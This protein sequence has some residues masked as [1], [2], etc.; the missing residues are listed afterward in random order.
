MHRSGLRVGEVLIGLF[1]V[2]VVWI[3][4]YS[5]RRP[6]MMRAQCQ[7]NL[8]QVSL[9]ILQY[10]RDWSQTLPPVAMS[11]A[12]ATA[13]SGYGWADAVMPYAI[14][15]TIFLCSLETRHD[16]NALPWQPGYTDYYYDSALAGLSLNSVNNGG[17]SVLLGEGA[18]GGKSTTAR[19]ALRSV[20]RDWMRIA[21][22]PT[23]R[24]LDGCNYGFVDGHVKWLA[25]RR[26]PLEPGIPCDAGFYFGT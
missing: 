24:H 19:Y 11:P 14:S 3:V 20:P 22:S 5:W 7:D 1:I 9:A 23:H 6:P 10:S 18:D 17:N 16:A 2:G 21:D 13:P 12:G 15:H 25:Y 26:V 4:V 8:R